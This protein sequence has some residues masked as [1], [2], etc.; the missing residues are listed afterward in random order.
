MKHIVKRTG[1]T[2][3]YDSKKLYASVYASCL[4]VRETAQTAEMIA[5]KVTASIDTWIE[6]K[7]EVTSLDITNNAYK[8]MI[9]YNE[10]AAWMYK[11]H[12]NVN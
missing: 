11:H 10:D 5:E 6:R 9:P 3:V 2:E 1:H 4:S 8:Y 7:T 12:R